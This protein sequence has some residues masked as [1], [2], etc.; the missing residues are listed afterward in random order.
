MRAYRS[1]FHRRL[2]LPGEIQKTVVYKTSRSVCLT[3]LGLYSGGAA[4]NIIAL[5]KLNNYCIVPRSE[6]ACVY[7]K[8]LFVS[9]SIKRKIC[10]GHCPN[11]Y[12]DACIHRCRYP[13]LASSKILNCPMYRSNKSKLLKRFNIRDR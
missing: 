7:A 1:R 4:M 3:G 13:G 9:G 2:Y 8:E 6:N 5:S 12:Y 10:C 11:R